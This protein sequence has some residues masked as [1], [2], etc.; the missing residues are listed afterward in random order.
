MHNPPETHN[1]FSVEQE[2]DLGDIEAQLLEDS[3]QVVHNAAFN[4]HVS[5]INNRLLAP[6]AV[7][8]ANIRIILIGAPQA[9]AF[10][11]GT[12]H[13]YITR[14]MIAM[15][16]NDDEFAGLLGHEL[17]HILAHQNA[18]V[19]SRAF[20]DVLGVSSVGDRNDIA[21]KF[22]RMLNSSWW[23]TNALPSA[24]QRLQSAD[25]TD[26]YQADRFALYAAAAVEVISC[27]IP[28]RS[29]A[30]E[31]STS[32]LRRTHPARPWSCG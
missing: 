27:I 31:W 2:Q 14:Q 24:T 30:S 5:A 4:A 32:D 12:S 26:Q 10:S 6:S 9:E 3:F 8:R 29:L 25:E 19:V 28:G 18:I 11:A 22:N 7:S 15:V 1:I 20:R 23:N 17:A 21:D 16:R 13:I